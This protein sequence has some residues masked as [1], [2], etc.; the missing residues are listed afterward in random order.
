MS[1]TDVDEF[2]G[3]EIYPQN[4]HLSSLDV[5]DARVAGRISRLSGELFVDKNVSTFRNLE[6]GVPNQGILSYS[7]ACKV[8]EVG[9]DGLREAQFVRIETIEK[10]SAAF[11]RPQDSSLL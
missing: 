2:D 4:L 10:L 11:R 6:L 7:D 9:V 8:A 1:R 3:W 5:D